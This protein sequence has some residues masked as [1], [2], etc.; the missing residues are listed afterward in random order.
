MSQKLSTSYP[1]WYRGGTLTAFKIGQLNYAPDGQCVISPEDP[2]LASVTVP[3]EWCE[4]NSPRVGGYMVVNADG[5]WWYQS[6]EVFERCHT[7]LNA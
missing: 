6:D 7:R 5:S 4:N 1:Q 3:V 2:T